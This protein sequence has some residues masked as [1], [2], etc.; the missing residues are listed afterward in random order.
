MEIELILGIIALVCFILC[1][2]I[3]IVGRISKAQRDKAAR[4]EAAEELARTRA[5]IALQR[6]KI[7]G[8]ER[9]TKWLE[10]DSNLSKDPKEG[11]L[12]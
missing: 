3:I 1:L 9:K 2:V 10:E 11:E 5:N 7:S 4:K 8:I 6:L 12:K